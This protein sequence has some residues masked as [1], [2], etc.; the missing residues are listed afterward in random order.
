MNSEFLQGVTVLGNLVHPIRFYIPFSSVTL[1]LDD[2]SM[3][4]MKSIHAVESFILRLV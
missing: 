2:L 3:V 4:N 1:Q